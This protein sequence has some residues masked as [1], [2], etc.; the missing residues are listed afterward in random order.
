MEIICVDGSFPVDKLE[1]YKLHG[2]SVPQQDKLYNIRAV[3]NNSNGKKG[4]LLEEIKNPTIPFKHP[5]IKPP[6]SPFAKSMFSTP[7]SSVSARP[8]LLPLPLLSTNSHH[9][10][11]DMELIYGN[12]EEEK[13]KDD[14][15]IEYSSDLDKEEE[16][17][18]DDFDF[19]FDIDV[20]YSEL[21]GG[22]KFFA[23][24]LKYK[25]KY[26]E[27]KSRLNKK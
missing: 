20:D 9:N 26:L 6:A 1:F 24:Y 5:I 25:N 15:D 18:K 21:G 17:K 10:N 12:E 14:M 13:K 16:E 22:K 27:L 11:G 7:S 2:V 19:D 23:K 3:I 8:S 4:I